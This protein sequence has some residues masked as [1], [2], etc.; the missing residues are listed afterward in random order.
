MLEKAREFYEYCYVNQFAPI[1]DAGYMQ[2]K[3][4][5][6]E[7][8]EGKRL[9]AALKNAHKKW[10]VKLLKDVTATGII[11]EDVRYFDGANEE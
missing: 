10:S 1:W 5:V 6:A 7:D 9:L 11:P 2:L 3:N 8:A 4:A